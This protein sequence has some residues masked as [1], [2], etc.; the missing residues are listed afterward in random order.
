MRRSLVGVRLSAF[1]A[2]VV[3]AALGYAPPVAAAG[4]CTEKGFTV[5]GIKGPPFCNRRPI[6]ECAKTRRATKC[7]VI[8]KF[9]GTDALPNYNYIFTIPKCQE[10]EPQ[11]T[12]PKKGKS[13]QQ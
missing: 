6:P 2:A 4:F 1:I 11:G 9:V 8:C 7:T 3:F 13:T 5:G 10:P 12:D